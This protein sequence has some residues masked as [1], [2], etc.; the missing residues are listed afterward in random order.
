MDIFL[1]VWLQKYCCGW[2]KWIWE[3]GLL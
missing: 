3:N 2:I 1:M